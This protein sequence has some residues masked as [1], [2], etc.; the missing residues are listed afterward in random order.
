MQLQEYPFVDEA[1]RTPTPDSELTTRATMTPTPTFS[2]GVE[3]ETSELADQADADA[4]DLTF[5]VD[6]L[7][8]ASAGDNLSV[9][10][11]SSARS[12][13]RADTATPASA[14]AMQEEPEEEPE[15]SRG[16][17]NPPRAASLSICVNTRLQEKKTAQ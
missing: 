5:D 9:G 1:G 4:D 14:S 8:T 6:G 12:V 3:L 7:E 11:R 10:G 15:V 16:S 2:D 13:R 17:A